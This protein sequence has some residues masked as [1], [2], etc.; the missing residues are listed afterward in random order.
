MVLGSTRVVFTVQLVWLIALVPALYAGAQLAGIA[1]AAAAHVCVALFVVLPLYLRRAAAG[2]H[3]MATARRGRRGPAACTAARSPSWRSPPPASSPS[4]CSAVAVAGTAV[5]VALAFEARRMRA[6]LAAAPVRHRRRDEL[7][8]RAR[9]N[10]GPPALIVRGPAPV[11]PV[12]KR[13]PWNP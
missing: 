12:R 7:T 3:R 10:A 2:G 9:K 6:A 4:T 8:V 1:G 13:E 5:L 11:G